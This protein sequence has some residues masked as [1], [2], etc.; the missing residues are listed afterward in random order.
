[1]PNSTRVLVVGAAGSGHREAAAEI[2][3]SLGAWLLN[4][5]PADQDPLPPCAVTL[6]R[7]DGALDGTYFVGSLS[8]IHDPL[9]S[10]NAAWCA[11]ER[12][13][14][15]PLVAAMPIQAVTPVSVHTLRM[16]TLALRP[17]RYV[18]VGEIAVE[19]ILAAQEVEEHS[20]SQDR[21][22]ARAER[23]KRKAWWTEY[24]ARCSD[25]EVPL[26][27]VRVRGA[28]LG[29]GLRLSP[30]DVADIRR[31]GVEGAVYAEVCGSTLFILTDEAH[32]GDHALEAADTFG[33]QTAH[34]TAATSLR[35]L[36]VAAENA[37]GRV[38]AVG[39]LREF[40]SARLTFHV[41]APV[42]PPMP[43]ETLLLGRIRIG[44]DGDELGVLKPWQ[45]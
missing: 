6:R 2:A 42:E 32:G 22:G 16:I 45:V 26:S 13:G 27:E 41:S 11:V 8:L 18:R 5:D 20:A 24:L 1:M 9:A 10:Q 44:E 31:I 40:D 21:L 12:V 19:H 33:C 25:H 37:A 17:S 36:V 3:E 23:P 15:E 39:R 28:R 4:L 34:L 35:G 7:P 29:A 30:S 38:F 14:G 43:I